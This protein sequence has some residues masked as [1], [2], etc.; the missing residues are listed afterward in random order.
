[1]VSCIDIFKELHTYKITPISLSYPVE[2][3]RLMVSAT[4]SD[5][6]IPASESRNREIGGQDSEATNDY[7]RT[8]PRIRRLKTGYYAVRLEEPWERGHTQRD[9]FLSI[10]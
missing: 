2:I 10:I 7:E 1:V 8:L 5:F 4:A 6:P 9:L 3:T